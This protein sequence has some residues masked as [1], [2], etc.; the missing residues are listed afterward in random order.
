M[1]AGRR[2]TRARRR[3]RS[4][5]GAGLFLSVLTALAFASM[6]SHAAAPPTVYHSTELDQSNPG[7][8][9][10]GE[11]VETL[12]LFL[13]TGAAASDSVN[14]EVCVDGDGDEVCGFTL[15][16]EAVDGLSLGS[17]TPDAGAGLV[18][19]L[20]TAAGALR[21]NR[22]GPALGPNTIL[23]L[24]SLQVVPGVVA[25]EIRVHA[26]SES[27]LARLQLES[28]DGNDPLAR[29]LPEPGAALGLALG[30][31][32]LGG[33]SR[34]RANR[35][36]SV[37]L[38][39]VVT[40]AIAAPEAGRA[41]LFTDAVAFEAA[42]GGSAQHITFD[43][44]PAQPFTPLGNGARIRQATFQS[45]SVPFDVDLE[46]VPGSP[47]GLFGTMLVHDAGAGPQLWPG[48][49]GSGG[50]PASDDDLRIDFDGPVRGAGVHILENLIEAGESI[51]FLDASGAVVSTVAL[52][53]SASLP[54]GDGFVGYLIQDGEPP[55]AAIVIDEAQTGA[56][57]I[58]IDDVIYDAGSDAFADAVS[59]YAPA[60]LAGE[61]VPA[62]RVP[63]EATG[64][65]DATTVSLGVGGEI[66]VRFVD[67]ALTGSGDAWADLRIYEAGATAEG[68]VIQVSANGL[69]WTTVGILAGGTESI[70]LDAFG[71]DA[72][73]RL[74]F[75]R[76][77]DRP[78]EG[79]LAGPSVGADID[80]VEALSSDFMP[81]DGDG[82][83]VPDDFDD[84]PDVY[85][86]KQVDTDA[87]GWGDR[88]DNCPDVFNPLQLD[89]DGDG[90]GDAC[91]PTVVRIRRDF[92]PSFSGPTE[93]AR[94]ELDCGTRA[95]EEVIVGLWV[96]PGVIMPRF[97]G[98]CAAPGSPPPGAP[99]GSG[100]PPG[101]VGTLLGSTV[102]ATNSG[103]FGVPIGVA[104]PPG[105]RTDVIF[106]VLQGAAA[107]G[108]LLCN[109][110]ETDVLLGVAD[111]T[112][113]VGSSSG[114]LS[115]SLEDSID[116]GWCLIS[117]NLGG[118]EEPEDTQYS[119][120]SF[121]SMDAEITIGPAAGQPAGGDD[122][123]DVC[124][125]ES[126]LP[127][128]HRVT[129][130]LLGP[131]LAT[132]DS[133]VL[134]GCDTQESIEGERTCDTQVGA[135]DDAVD[136]PLTFTV[137]P[138]TAGVPP[139]LGRTLY[140]G[141]E[142]GSEDTGGV[143]VLNPRLAVDACIGTVTNAA[144]ATSGAPPTPIRDGFSDLDFHDAVSLGVAEPY[145]TA[146]QVQQVTV[147]LDGEAVY[148][149]LLFNAGDD[150][151][152]DGV[153]DET[154]N[155]PFTANADQ[156][157]AGAFG[158]SVAD[159]AGDACQCGDANGSG[160][161][162]AD[163]QE[164]GTSDVTMLREWLVGLH[165]TDLHIPKICSVNGDPEC[166]TADAVA[167]ARAL[168]G[169]NATIEPRCEA[170]VD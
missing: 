98:G 112:G 117:S 47:L 20:D 96:P 27:V 91:E 165:P 18:A 144:P 64:P 100:C 103:A 63:G 39:L 19:N 161:V 120:G 121:V 139:L 54:G 3:G 155:C 48:A 60:I 59:S 17:F 31:L 115:I 156:A 68:S 71:F 93:I 34:R 43:A 105:S 90:V 149:R 108:G 58:G 86:A 40:L 9:T 153:T 133:M 148:E 129:V 85:D 12:S 7:T 160:A 87:D 38:A 159:G 141:I 50:G 122:T 37:G 8:H 66:V 106:V 147:E 124:I 35:G 169:A 146:D 110:F 143:R 82:D 132:Y 36:A 69:A 94:L 113:L 128:M 109:P 44:A 137:G 162:L 32:V 4:R 104:P 15:V 51:Q 170:A 67:N 88:C 130:G 26:E 21:I 24:G 55:I 41:Q 62:E 123:W 75:V 84:C 53:G 49:S 72:Q 114:L 136:E 78:L 138:L 23:P 134:G 14:E 2:D 83:G 163:G 107:N 30:G 145:Q 16:I 164:S 79:P 6:A 65:P 74:Y 99:I 61:P 111:A 158:S 52:P 25:G 22:L 126:T 140:A 89:S 101:A 97:G 152:V 135:T 80:A 45:L 116:N 11:S 142:G 57:E 56:D 73:D 81:P 70:D 29:Y 168:D 42:L 102:D 28:I 13:A 127:L 118:C 125:D 77:T 157:D 167:L 166:D 154:D 1:R 150:I 151:D 10:V 33:L 46:W 119:I 92:S 76:I 5:L 95:I 131:E